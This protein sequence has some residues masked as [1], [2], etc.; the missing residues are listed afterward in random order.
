MTPE[1]A[2]PPL[3][4]EAHDGTLI[5]Y[6]VS[7][8]SAPDD[9]RPVLLVHGFASDA[10][11]TWIRTGWVRALN[12]AGRPV[13]TVDLRGHGAS[14]APITADAYAPAVLGADLLAVLDSA[15]ADTVDVVAYSLGNRV[16]SA[17]A[18]LAPERIASVV[19]GGAGPRELFAAWDLDEARAYIIEDRKPGNP[20]IAQVLGPALEAGAD[21]SVLLAVIA[22]MSGSELAVPGGIRTLFV[23]GENDP[24]PAGAQDLA[25]EW[26][27]GF[28]TVPGRDHIST[29]TSRHFKDAVLGFLDGGGADTA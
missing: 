21:P 4:A 24:V 25:H 1:S 29:L 6:R 14:D 15:G 8:A 7:A 9:A 3:Y 16:V 26:G 5:A 20:L 17:L 12:A 13:I 27:A 22:G 11:T 10:E 2:G 18:E 19:I 28:V 23:V